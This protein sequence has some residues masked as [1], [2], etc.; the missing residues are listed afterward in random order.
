MSLQQLPLGF[1]LRDDSTFASFLPGNNQQV[2]Q[3]VINFAKGV[4]DNFLYLYGEGGCGRSHLL[5]AICHAAPEYNQS[6]VY[7][8]LSSQTEA[9]GLVLGF[10]NVHIVCLDDIDQIAG[11]KEL[12]EEVF[13]LF[14]RVRTMNNRLIVTANTAPA[15]LS[16]KL[17]DLKSRLAWGVS[18][19]LQPLSDEQK[20][21]ALVLRAKYRGFTLEPIVGKFLLRRC[22][23]NMGQLFDTLELLDQASLSQQ[24]RL[25]IPFVKDVLGV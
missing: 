21:A 15:N 6:V 24:R 1:R 16:I 11:N 5:Q 20:L 25:T 13:H 8:P 23:R 4:G 17:A 18:Y 2:V 19:Q 22:P 10:E 12:E 9:Q 14:N 3:A 7:F